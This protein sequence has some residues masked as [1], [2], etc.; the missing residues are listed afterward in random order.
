MKTILCWD[1][2]RAHRCRRHC[3]LFD[4]MSLNSS[5]TLRHFG[6]FAINFNGFAIALKWSALPITAATPLQLPHRQHRVERILHIKR[7]ALAQIFLYIYDFTFIL[8]Y[9]FKYFFPV[10]FAVNANVCGNKWS[11]N[12][13][14]P[15]IQNGL[16]EMIAMSHPCVDLR[17]VLHCNRN[18]S[19]WLR[20]VDVGASIWHLVHCVCCTYI[21]PYQRHWN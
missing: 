12:E 16:G 7:V 1:C 10:R 6:V 17:M 11:R 3:S 9:F 15:A 14:W 20:R 13:L 4:P 8:R 2:V 21:G 5:Q 19:A 18:S